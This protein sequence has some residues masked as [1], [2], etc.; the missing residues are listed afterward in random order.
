MRLRH[1]GTR[2]LLGEGF[3]RYITRSASRRTSRAW[4]A[5]PGS[6]TTADAR[7]HGSS[8]GVDVDRVGQLGAHASASPPVPSGTTATNPSPP[9]RPTTD[10]DGSAVARRHG[11]QDGVS[12]SVAVGVVDR[13]EV[14]EVDE[15]DHHSARSVPGQFDD[16]SSAR[17][18]TCRC[19]R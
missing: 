13:L 9:I 16:E 8:V 11:T 14:V 2:R 10:R 19:G 5:A 15:Q 6:T 12:D 3:E 17:A 4:Y 7:R 18:G 1:E